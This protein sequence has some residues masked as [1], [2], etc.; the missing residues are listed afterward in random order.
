ME[1]FWTSADKIRVVLRNI[2]CMYRCVY[3]Q[4]SILE[5]AAKV[6]QF[7]WGHE[8]ENR[9]FY[10]T[11]SQMVTSKGTIKLWNNACYPPE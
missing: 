1:G 10:R 3:T 11:I 6:A 5:Q 9:V 7:P 4:D 2:L 8:E